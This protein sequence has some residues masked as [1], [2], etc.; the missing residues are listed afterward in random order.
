MPSRCI[1]S[2]GIALLALVATACGS[3]SADPSPPPVATD[4]ASAITE[5]VVTAPTTVATT[6]PDATTATTTTTVA[7]TPPPTAAVPT[8]PAGWSPIDLD[9]VS[10]KA[11]P[12]CCADTWHGDTSPAWSPPGEP[13]ADGPYAVITQWPNDRS[14][15][16]ELELYRFEQCSLL[17]EFSCEETGVEYLPDELGVDLSVSR[18]LT[19]PLDGTTRVVVV[20]WDDTEPVRVDVQEATGSELADL[21]TAVEDA[22]A[23]VFAERF[24]AGEAPETILADVLANP[25]G[26]F[27]PAVN[28]FQG[29]LYTPS[30]GPGLLF[31]GVFPFRDGGRVVGRGTDVLVIPS[32]EVVDGVVTLNVYAAYYS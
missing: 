6:T 26:G 27:T 32:I 2:I 24:L 29:F 8:A 13:L 23:I 16:L 18:Q 17:P 22:Y 3:E 28:S 25:I 30:A 4:A 1:R 7:E 5:P 31:Q 15:P 20:G 10:D 19:V 9:S 12:P 21:A 14:G 11:F